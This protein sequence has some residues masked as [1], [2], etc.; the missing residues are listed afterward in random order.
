MTKK[1]L[2]QKR[3]ELHK[4]YARLLDENVDRRKEMVYI[5]ED[6]FIKELLGERDAKE[7]YKELL[8]YLQKCA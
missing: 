2:Q 7:E 1:E 6:F 4:E 3:E 8:K 5:A